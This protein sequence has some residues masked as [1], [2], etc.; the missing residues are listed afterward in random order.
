MTSQVDHTNSAQLINQYMTYLSEAQL[1]PGMSQ[2][3][4]NKILE[5]YKKLNDKL[6][7]LSQVHQKL[8]SMD[9]SGA[10]TGDIV[11]QIER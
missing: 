11:K 6:S 10:P 9:N 2:E 7:Q 3:K 5:Q 8:G 4:C 1:P